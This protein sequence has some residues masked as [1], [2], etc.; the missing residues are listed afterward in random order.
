GDWF[1]PR[2]ENPVTV[3]ASATAATTSSAIQTSSF[4]VITTAA[5]ASAAETTTAYPGNVSDVTLVDYVFGVVNATAT[6]VTGAV[7]NDA[8]QKLADITIS[9]TATVTASRPEWTGIGLEW[10]RRSLGTRE[11][12]L[13]CIDVKVRI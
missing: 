6:A 11:W 8:K 10:I 2:F 3:T 4:S 7:V 9:S 1:S 13:P 5:M 12:T